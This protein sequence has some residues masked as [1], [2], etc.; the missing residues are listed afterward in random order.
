MKWQWFLRPVALPAFLVG[1]LFVIVPFG[2]IVTVAG[3]VFY[4]LAVYRAYGRDRDKALPAGIEDD[5]GKLPYK[6][7]RLAELAIAAAR[8]VERR[9]TALPR[10]L[11]GRVPVVPAEA[12]KLAGG[13]V[14][15][16][17]READAVALAKTASG[18]GMESVAA[19][20]GRRA[21]DLFKRIQE[22]QTALG[23]LALEAGDTAAL[24]LQASEATREALAMMQA[25]EAARRELEGGTP[26]TALPP[27]TDK[28]SGHEG[29]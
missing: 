6:R 3:A 13:V 17:R 2:P 1:L 9:L 27:G 14:F 12:G 16:L 15:Y 25:M 5:V 10:D 26:A 11:A 24:A 18:A 7:R 23:A 20:A 22:L 8:D 29:S 4:A 19:E 28:S 21:E